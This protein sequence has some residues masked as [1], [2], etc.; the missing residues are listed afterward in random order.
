V[1]PAWSPIFSGTLPIGIFFLALF[2]SLALFPAPAQAQIDGWLVG[3]RFACCPQSNV[4]RQYI[5]LAY[6]AYP[7]TDEARRRAVFLK[8]QVEG[9]RI[10]PS[11]DTVDITAM[12]QAILG[13]PYESGARAVRDFQGVVGA[14]AD[15]NWGQS[16]WGAVFSFFEEL[17]TPRT[18]MLDDRRLKL[19]SVRRD[20]LNLIQ[21]MAMSNAVE[22]ETLASSSIPFT[23]LNSFL[24]WEHSRE[25]GHYSLLASS[26][27]LLNYM[28]GQNRQ[29]L[30]QAFHFMPHDLQQAVS[31]MVDD[32][33]RA[34]RQES[35]SHQLTGT[36]QN[37]V[38]SLSGQNRQNLLLALQRLPADSQQAVAALVQAREEAA[39]QSL[40]KSVAQLQTKL[41]Q[42]TQETAQSRDLTHPLIEESRRLVDAA[43]PN[44]LEVES[45][46]QGLPENQQLFLSVLAD[47]WQSLARANLAQ[48]FENEKQR[49]LEERKHLLNV[50][51]QKFDNSSGNRQ[52]RLGGWLFAFSIATLGLAILFLVLAKRGQKVRMSARQA[53]SRKKAVFDASEKQ[54]KPPLS[55]SDSKVLQELAKLEELLQFTGRDIH[56]DIARYTMDLE[57]L[58]GALPGLADSEIEDKTIKT[59]LEKI[60]Q[61]FEEMEEQSLNPIQEGYKEIVSRMDD[62]KKYIKDSRS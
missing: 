58:A 49:L 11:R 47:E 6:V 55:Q 5:V 7:L 20:D 29:N 54:K 40:N 31:I 59:L 44:R 22:N 27:R 42:A 23:V 34:A 13:R 25:P 57:K 53:H 8:Y 51:D 62:L 50:L 18:I 43:G 15:G 21:R 16:T 33:E 3:Y 14:T 39:K 56:P 52:Q 60:V 9:N 10:Y 35:S 46:L 32:R 28:S 37:F 2:F 36:S 48:E 24:Q 4:N 41:A 30:R 61:G 1:L 12:R 19:V 26:E 38:N 17:E 45:L